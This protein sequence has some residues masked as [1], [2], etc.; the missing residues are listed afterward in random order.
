MA[1]EIFKRTRTVGF[2]VG[3]AIYLSTFI[4]STCLT[5]IAVFPRFVNWEPVVPPA[6]KLES[7]WRW[8]AAHKVASHSADMEHEYKWSSWS[9]SASSTAGSKKLRK[10]RKNLH[11]GG[12]VV[13]RVLAPDAHVESTWDSEKRGR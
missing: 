2:R 12:K 6:V 9:W 4:C 10:E 13:S 11:A 3:L 5:G 8:P 7:A 1:P